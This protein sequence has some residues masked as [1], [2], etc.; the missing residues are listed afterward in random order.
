MPRVDHLFLL[1]IA[2][3]PRDIFAFFLQSHALPSELL[4]AFSQR[5]SSVNSKENEFPVV[6]IT[7]DKSEVATGQTK[8]F[9]LSPRA[10]VPAPCRPRPESVLFRLER[11]LECSEPRRRGRG[12]RERRRKGERGRGKRAR[13]KPRGFSSTRFSINF[14]LRMS[15]FPRLPLLISSP[16]SRRA[17]ASLIF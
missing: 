2:D 4:S 17:P 5:L 10:R 8:K 13:L 15:F 6:Y 12:K 7:I 11:A 9:V 16:P 14:P 3:S 1:R